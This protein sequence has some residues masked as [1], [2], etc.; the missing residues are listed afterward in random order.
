MEEFMSI[1]Q[2]T[3]GKFITFAALLL[4]PFTGYSQNDER[5]WYNVLPGKFYTAIN[6][7]KNLECCDATDP[8]KKYYFK[9]EFDL[10]PTVYLRDT[11]MLKAYSVEVIDSNIIRC[12]TARMIKAF[13]KKY[14]RREIKK[15]KRSCFCVDVI[16]ITQEDLI[17]NFIFINGRAQITYTFQK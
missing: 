12:E 4:L 1:R 13:R 7:E 6:P 3:L 5:E 15:F 17:D 8:I 11:F 14:S 9:Y 2:N 16:S 10:P